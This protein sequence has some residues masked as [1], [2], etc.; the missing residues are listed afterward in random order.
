LSFALGLVALSRPGPL[1]DLI[2]ADVSIVI[3]T[4]NRAR[5]LPAALEAICSIKTRH[6]WECIVV[7]NVSTDDTAA[8]IAEFSDKCVFIAELGFDPRGKSPCQRD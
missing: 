4:R 6:R 1:S 2:D 7:D 8:V 3:C 5:R